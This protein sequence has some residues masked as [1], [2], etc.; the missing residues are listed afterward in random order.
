M[1]KSLRKSAR[2][3]FLHVLY[4]QIRDSSTNQA[5]FDVDARVRGI[6]SIAHS[7][8]WCHALLVA[9]QPGS[10]RCHAA[11]QRARHAMWSAVV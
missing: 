11:M 8:I 7:R 4:L 3:A 5:R 2:N 6:R 9:R 1:V 10:W